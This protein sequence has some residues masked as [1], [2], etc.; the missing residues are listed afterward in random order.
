[1]TFLPNGPR[2]RMQGKAY[3]ELCRQILD[4]DGWRCQVCGSRS[5]LEVHHMQFRSR[6]GDDAEQNLITLCATCHRNNREVNLTKRVQTPHG[7]RYCRVVLSAN[8][9]VKPDVV[10]VNGKPENHPEGA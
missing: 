10:I 3:R 2:I 4:R 5:N 1:M 9:R 7:S 8:G 6:S